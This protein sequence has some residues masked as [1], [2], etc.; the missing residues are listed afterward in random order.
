MGEQVRPCPLIISIKCPAQTHPLRLS[1]KTSKDNTVPLPKIPQ[2]QGGHLGRP[3]PPAC[4]FHLHFRRLLAW[5]L[6]KET[7]I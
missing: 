3:H 7:R 2:I 6:G 5:P 1:L 4:H